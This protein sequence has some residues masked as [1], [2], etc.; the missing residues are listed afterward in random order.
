[1]GVLSYDDIT[2]NSLNPQAYADGN[3]RTI[4]YGSFQTFGF[5]ILI[6]ADGSK[7]LCQDIMKMRF[8][9]SES[10]QNDNFLLSATFI[11]SSINMPRWEF[12]CRTVHF[13]QKIGE[14]PAFSLTFSR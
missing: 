7:Q 1:M 11:N 6:Y 4:S 9:E 3:G 14:I 8:D 13:S 10:H 12:K 5:T 2:E